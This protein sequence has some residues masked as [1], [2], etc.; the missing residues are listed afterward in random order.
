MSLRLTVGTVLVAD[1]RI[2]RD[3]FH[4]ARIFPH[5][6]VELH[7]VIGDETDGDLGERRRDDEAERRSSAGNRIF[8]IAAAARTGCR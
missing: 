5:F 2:G 4:V 3:D 7:A 1:Q 8:F 6:Q